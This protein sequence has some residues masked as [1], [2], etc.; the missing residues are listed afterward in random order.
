MVPLPGGDRDGGLGTS[1]EQEREDEEPLFGALLDEG[2]VAFETLEELAGVGGFEGGALELED[3]WGFEGGAL[4]EGEAV[5]DET[6][7]LLEVGAGFEQRQD[8][9]AEI[10]ADRGLKAEGKREVGE[11]GAPGQEVGEAGE[12]QAGVEDRGDEEDWAEGAGEDGGRDVLARSRKSW[13]ESGGSWR[14]RGGRCVRG[15]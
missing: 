15:E 13:R 14:L 11:S 5:G 4:D 2:E 3:F 1:G 7:V 12:E 10:E 6:D 9:R 8:A